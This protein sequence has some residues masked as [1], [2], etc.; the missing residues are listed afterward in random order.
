[1][2]LQGLWNVFGPDTT[3]G[4]QLRSLFGNPH[5]RN[6][7][8]VTYP[9]LRTRPVRVPSSPPQREKRTQIRY[10]K[11]APSET[12]TETL[13]TRPSRRSALVIK[14][15]SQHDLPSQPEFPTRTKDLSQEKRKLQDAFQFSSSRNSA[16][17][18][19]M[20]PE[21]HG[22]IKLPVIV[23]SRNTVAKYH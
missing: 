21:F 23:D 3:T 4:R 6:S 9:K 8:K 12:N 17:T 10:P 16:I 5:G 1:M 15:S 22:E 20:K 2:E 7:S 11:F 13:R 19:A 14:R 18:A